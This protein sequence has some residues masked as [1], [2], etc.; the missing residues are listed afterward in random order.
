M[1]QICGQASKFHANFNEI[2]AALL[3]LTAAFFLLTLTAAPRS[4]N[5]NSGRWPVNLNGRAVNLNAGHERVN[6]NAAAVNL[7]AAGVPLWHM[8]RF[9]TRAPPNGRWPHWLVAGIF[10][11][12]LFWPENHF[13]FGK[14][15]WLQAPPSP[16]VAPF[17]FIWRPLV[18]GS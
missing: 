10:A 11:H 9:G 13:W 5:L 2:W 8:C 14:A 15:L 16:L 3:R 12:P 1:H 18:V 4:V 6:L 17:F 7:N